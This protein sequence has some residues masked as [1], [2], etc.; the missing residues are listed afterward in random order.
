[1]N[2]AKAG[3]TQRLMAQK[4]NIMP[5]IGESTNN[6]QISQS[7]FFSI[8]FSIQDYQINIQILTAF[9]PFKQTPGFI[10]LIRPPCFSS[11][12]LSTQALCT[13]SSFCVKSSFTKYPHDSFSLF[14]TFRSLLKWCFLCEAFC[15]HMTSNSQNS[16]PPN[17]D[18]VFSSNLLPLDLI[19]IYWW[20]DSVL[21][22]K[23]HVGGRWYL[24]FIHHVPSNYHNTGML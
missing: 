17:P 7:A 1:M 24:V 11:D 20:T 14:W 3:M 19:Y 5:E 9:Y 22:C 6:Q 8:T 18:W 4:K 2:I 23:L 12:I 13:W 16:H 10:K 15:D 21:E